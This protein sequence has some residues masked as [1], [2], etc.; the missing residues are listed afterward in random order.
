MNDLRQRLSARDYKHA[1]RA[2]GDGFDF[3]QYR[4]LGIGLAIGLAVALGVWLYDH[5]TQPKPTADLADVSGPGARAGKAA[6][7]QSAA[8]ETEADPA[9]DYAFYEALPKFEVTVPEK[10]HGARRDLPD[11]AIAQAGAYVLQV[12]SYRNR[13]DADR[14]ADKLSKL[15]IQ[16]NVQHIAI[17]ADEWNRVR[18][19]PI[20]DLVK[21]NSTRKQLRAADIDA[22]IYRVGD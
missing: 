8:A 6:P 3:S 2:P 17:D 19:G 18:I 14:L 22:V 15:G 1:R 10:D 9:K 4:Q 5:R 20:S 7:K 11:E 12:G 13:P 21:L 16:A